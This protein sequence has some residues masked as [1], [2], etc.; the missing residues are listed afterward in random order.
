MYSYINKISSNL[1][2]NKPISC[3]EINGYKYPSIAQTIAQIEKNINIKNS[4]VTSNLDDIQE[5]DLD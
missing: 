2:L 3:I 4:K 1:I 5:I